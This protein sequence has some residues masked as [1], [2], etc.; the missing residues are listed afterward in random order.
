MPGALAPDPRS[1]DT[2]LLHFSHLLGQPPI[3]WGRGRPTPPPGTGPPGLFTSRPGR[4]W[5]TFCEGRYEPTPAAGVSR[6]CTV[7]WN[8]LR[9]A[10]PRR[11]HRIGSICS[12]NFVRFS[13]LT[14][15]DAV[16]TREGRRRQKPGHTRHRAFPRLAPRCGHHHH[17]AEGEAASGDSSAR[18][19]AIPL[20]CLGLRSTLP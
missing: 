19:T 18:S 8:L 9:R 4:P 1:V 6:R 10:L 16:G 13:A 5:G 12:R 14:M 7:R 11:C 15:N 3:P 17:R 2:D 20:G